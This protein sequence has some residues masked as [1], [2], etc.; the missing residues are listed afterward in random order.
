MHPRPCSCLGLGSRFIEE[1]R[2]EA[3]LAFILSIAVAPHSSG[4]SPLQHYN[5]LLA[6]SWLQKFVDG[7]VLFQNDIVLEQAENLATKGALKGAAKP[8][9]P[10]PSLQ[11]MNSYIA[12]CLANALM[13]TDKRQG[14]LIDKCKSPTQNTICTGVSCPNCTLHTAINLIITVSEWQSR[15]RTPIA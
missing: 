10:S 6:T 2:T 11:A 1:V 9:A 5:A 4:D 13:P 3:P 14:S 15:M 7:V 8:C 12:E